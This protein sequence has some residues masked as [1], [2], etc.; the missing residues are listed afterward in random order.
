MTR[1]G[2]KVAMMNITSQEPCE[3]KKS[4]PIAKYVPTNDP[5]GPST[6]RP[7]VPTTKIVNIGT[8]IIFMESCIIRLKKGSIYDCAH[9]VRRIGT[10]DEL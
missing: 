2:Q 7:I 5:N 10:T 3:P 9:T 8:K 4:K 1:I 6:V